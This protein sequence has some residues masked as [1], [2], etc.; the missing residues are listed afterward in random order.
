M[1]VGIHI[2]VE[3]N[4]ANI[5]VVRSESLAS[6]LLSVKILSIHIFVVYDI[7]AGKFHILRRCVWGIY[8]F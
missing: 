6:F 2:A 7:Y 4:N 8:P 5:F 1:T 3:Q